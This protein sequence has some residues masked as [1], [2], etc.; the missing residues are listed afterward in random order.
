MY[1]A[2]KEKVAA[3]VIIVMA[4]RAKWILLQDKR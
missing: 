3:Y 1:E 4:H 2:I